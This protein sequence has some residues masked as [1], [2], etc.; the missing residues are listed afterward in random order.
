TISP[1]FTVSETLLT[2]LMPPKRTLRSRTSSVCGRTCRRLAATSLRSIRPTQRH[3]AG[4]RTSQ[5]GKQSPARASVGSAARAIS[6]RR[7]PA[8]RRV[9]IPD[10]RD[11][12]QMIL[13]RCSGGSG[14]ACVQALDDLPV[15]FDEEVGLEGEGCRGLQ[16]E[17]CGGDRVE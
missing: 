15:F 6:V 4:Y 2:A 12:I 16:L 17:L 9:P 13:H 10:S 3:S 11:V 8:A 14:I 5:G 7:P 1:G